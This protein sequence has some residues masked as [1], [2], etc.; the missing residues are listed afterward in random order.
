MLDLS[1]GSRLK[2]VITNGHIQIQAADNSVEED[3]IVSAF[4]DFL[5]ADMVKNPHAL[6]PLGRDLY[7]H[8]GDTVRDV[9]IDL[10]ERIEGPVSLGQ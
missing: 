2:W 1:A 8:L 4:L 3:P 7:D 9:D 10:D 6:V 5:E